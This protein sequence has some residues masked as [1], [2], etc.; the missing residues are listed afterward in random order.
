MRSS[1]AGGARLLTILAPRHPRARRCARGGDRGGRPFAR[2]PLARRARSAQAPTSTSPTRSARWAF[3]IGSPTLLSSAAR[4]CRAAGR[5]RSSRQSSACPILHGPHVG[6]FRDVYDAL[7]AAASGDGASSDGASLA[8]AVKLL[9]DD[10]GERERLAREAHACIERFTGA[11]E[12]TLDALEPYLAPLCSDHE[13]CAARLI[14]GGS[15]HTP[16]GYRARAARR[17]LRRASPAAAWRGRASRWASR[18]SASAIS[19]SAAPARR[20]PRSKWRMS[21]ASSG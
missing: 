1:L 9:I 13:C 21:A 15:G 2:P 8:A 12:R 5:I 18:S 10:A 4:W 7:T 17:D 6:N 14:S 20:R 3:G 19:S 16:A 11:L